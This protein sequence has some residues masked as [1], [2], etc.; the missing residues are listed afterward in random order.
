M[1][2]FLR[3]NGIKAIKYSGISKAAVVESFQRTLQ[4]HLY[5]HIAE[6]ESLEYASILP[7]IVNSYNNQKHTSTG[8]TPT[9]IIEN[10]EIQEHLRSKTV[11][12]MISDKKVKRSPKYK[13]GDY[14]R[15]KLGGDK[16]TRSYNLRN[17]IERFRIKQ[18]DSTKKEPR[19]FLEEEDA[20]EIVGSFS[21][22]ELTLCKIDRF[23]ATPLE[24]K[25]V[26]G[27]KMTLF[28][29]KGYSD[30]YN[31]WEPSE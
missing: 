14:V 26:R 2:N 12:K 25:K 6:H 21:S 19:Y 13:V 4:R 29:W 9:E 31:S 30:K 10:K 7:H 15:V 18:V 11:L 23:K 22:R 1:L 16:F 24:E 17:T 8:Y 27:Q 5:T 20:T 28:K 3:S